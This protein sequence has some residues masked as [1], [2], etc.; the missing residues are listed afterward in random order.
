MAKKANSELV[1][2]SGESSIGG[3]LDQSLQIY[4]NIHKVGRDVCTSYTR[5]YVDR[6]SQ[7]I[8]PEWLHERAGEKA[9]ISSGIDYRV[10]G[11]T[12]Y[13]ILER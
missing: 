13:P 10:A 12:V 3:E 9:V 1:H 5:S 7:W 2:P 8:Q 6:S 11:K 4:G